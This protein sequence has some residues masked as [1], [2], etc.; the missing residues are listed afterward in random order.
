MVR[1]DKVRLHLERNKKMS[2]VTA[3]TIRTIQV[4]IKG[5]SALLMHRFPMTT[6]EGFENLSKEE[7]AEHAAY[8]DPNT[9][10]LYIPGVAIQRAIIAAATFSK[11]KGRASLQKPVAACVTVDPERISLGTK[12]YVIDSRPV[13]IK[14]TKGRIIRHR[15]KLEQWQCSFTLEYDTILLKEEQMHKIVEDTGRRAGLLD[16]RPACKG[17]FG[18]FIIVNWKPQDSKK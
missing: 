18:R 13:V 1:L 12:E 2:T 16:F 5:V 11:G 15:P 10:E 4:T 3:K 17:P 7:Q 6:I 9:K 14:V 8:R